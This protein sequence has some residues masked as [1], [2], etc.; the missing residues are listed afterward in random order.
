MLAVK[1]NDLS[2]KVVSIKLISSEEILATCLE[3]SPTL[4]IQY[5][6][7]LVVGASSQGSQAHVSFTPWMISVSYDQTILLQDSQIFFVCEAGEHAASQYKEAIK[8][9][10]DAA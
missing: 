2:G 6:L 8:S 4:R 3:S 1:K 7:S 10:T 9:K 5:P